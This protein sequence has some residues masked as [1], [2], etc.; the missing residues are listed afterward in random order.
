MS[1]HQERSKFIIPLLILVLLLLSVSGALLLLKLTDIK[2]RGFLL[3]GGLTLNLFLL[4]FLVNSFLR[5]GQELHVATSFALLALLV[6]GLALAWWHRALAKDTLG[7]NRWEYL[8]LALSCLVIWVSTNASQMGLQDQ[9]F[10]IHAPLQRHLFDGHFPPRNP[11]FTELLLHGH[12]G[13]DLLIVILA[14]LSGWDTLFS[15]FMVTSFCHALAA[16]VL[17]LGFRHLT[18][19]RLQA[20]L[21]T[22]FLFF[23]TNTAYRA[24]WIDE[25]VAHSPVAHL[26]WAL[27]VVLVGVWSKRPSLGL[28]LCLGAYLGVSS[29]VF[30]TSFATCWLVFSI[31]LLAFHRRRKELLQGLVVLALSLLLAGVQGGALSHYLQRTLS[32]ASGVPQA[33]HNQSQSVELH[34]PK[35]HILAFAKQQSDRSQSCAYSF[36][37]ARQFMQLV[38][39]QGTRYNERYAPLWSW[40]VLRLHWLALYLSP[41]SLLGLATA[42]HRSGLFCWMVGAISF[43]TPGIFNFGPVHEEDWLRWVL[44]T[45]TGF[46]AALGLCLGSWLERSQGRVRSLAWLCLPLAIWLNTLAGAAYLFSNVPENIRI[47]GGFWRVAFFRLNSEEWLLK[48]KSSLRV[49]ET[50]L[51]AFR[52]LKS[53]E[54][55][56]QR[57]LVNFDPEDPWSILFESSLSAVTG[58]FC[59]GHALPLDTDPIGR[60]PGRM[61]QLA[62]ELLEEP[63]T[64]ALHSLAPDWIYLKSDSPQLVQKLEALPRV[65][66]IWQ[67]KGQDGLHRIILKVTKINADKPQE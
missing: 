29:F 37:P 67:G 5:I 18:S 40:D 22:L 30:T 56:G 55:Q 61:T 44:W 24:G 59:L 25:F 26:H 28:S 9:D 33:Q 21:S 65:E 35:S 64:E 45:G 13:R 1:Q 11:Y 6:L 31:F 36:F 3:S 60:P 43:V 32:S 53:Q 38:D 51:E 50:D 54:I 17:Y 66:S 10:W 27:L 47:Q 62:S 48:H 14:K 58:A 46:S 39:H 23:G 20:G 41:L 7:G 15:K 52:W 57:V 16:P 34:F 12:Y 8:V 4:L 63:K 49:T 2:E 42:R 19:S